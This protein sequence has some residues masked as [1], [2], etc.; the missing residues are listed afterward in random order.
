INALILG[1]KNDSILFVTYG[2]LRRLNIEELTS[3]VI[4]ALSRIS[5]GDLFYQTVINSL[6][7]HFFLP[8]MVKNKDRDFRYMS[9]YELFNQ[10]FDIIF[11]P[12]CLI[13]T[14]VGQP[15]LSRRR[16]FL[17]DKLCLTLTG[18][19]NHLAST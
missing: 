15:Y 19:P 2:A 13:I 5:L 7:T 18:A 16:I 11:N 9:E 1:D 17:A 4:Q 12:I 10:A 8:K 3:L 6:L 14:W